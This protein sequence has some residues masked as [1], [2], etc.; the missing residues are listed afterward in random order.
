MDNTK[1]ETI[2]VPAKYRP[3]KYVGYPLSGDKNRELND[4]GKTRDKVEDKP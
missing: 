1:S 3:E 2:T 4:V